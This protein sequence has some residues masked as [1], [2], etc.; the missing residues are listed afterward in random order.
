M[1]TIGESYSA[2]ALI[3][4]Y[5]CNKHTHTEWHTNLHTHNTHTH[6]F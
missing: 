3:E 1:S 6:I 2:G 5:T 4:F